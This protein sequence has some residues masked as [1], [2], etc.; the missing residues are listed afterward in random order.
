MTY[1]INLIDLFML[2]K[3]SSEEALER[4]SKQIMTFDNEQQTNQG[5][6]N[7]NE[8]LARYKLL[9]QALLGF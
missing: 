5:T 2:H 7:V 3:V 9:E 4:Y 6:G 1:S 8:T